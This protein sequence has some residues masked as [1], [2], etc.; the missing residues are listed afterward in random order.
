MEKQEHH[1]NVYAFNHN[2]KEIHISD[3]PYSERGIRA[4]Y[5]CMGC[6]EQM[7]AVKSVRRLPHFRH[8][9]HPNSPKRK[10]TYS[11]ESYRHKLAKD[12]LEVKK[13]IKV[14]KVYKY[15]PER[16]NPAK[17][18][19]DS[20]IIMC[21]KVL[22]EHHLFED[23]NG[24]LK[25]MHKPDTSLVAGL[26]V[27]PDVM[28]LNKKGEPILLIEIVAT[29]KVDVDKQVKYKRIGIDTVSVTIPKDSPQNIENVFNQTSRTKWIY[30]YEEERTDYLR[31]PNSNS[32]TLSEIDKIQRKFFEETYKCRKTELGELIRSI[33]RLLETE[34]YKQIERDI[35]SEIQRIE[36]ATK[37]AQD[38]LERLRNKHGAR[39]ISKYSE[40][41]AELT[42]AE[43]EFQDYSGGLEKRYRSKKEELNSEESNT[44]QE[45]NEIEK[46]FQSIQSERRGTDEACR[47]ERETIGQLELDKSRIGERV[48]NAETQ[49]REDTVRLREQ[50]DRDYEDIIRAIRKRREALQ[51]KDGGTGKDGESHI[52]KDIRRERANI[53][54]T[55]STLNHHRGR[56]AATNSKFN[57]NYER[58]ERDIRIIREGDLEKVIQGHYKGSRW[59]DTEYERLGEFK[60]SLILYKKVWAVSRG[61]DSLR[62]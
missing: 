11:D 46:R 29:H 16:L 9:T 44:N 60:R 1:D 28:F 20:E 10:C 48:S 58:A 33:E 41:R 51:G 27:K 39:G 32:D 38:E 7:Q 47:E 22:K 50:F 17:F 45:S 40:R 52:A 4:K 61:V 49:Y 36:R 37:T 62:S 30:N 24:E 53:D 23:V 18:L 25:I 13:A 15:D 21:H 8:H 5:Y 34:Q 42:K 12:I 3:I 35:R 55:R 19:K 14:P 56:R 43:G 57:E 26:W 54:R 59:F 2:F 31:L 6:K